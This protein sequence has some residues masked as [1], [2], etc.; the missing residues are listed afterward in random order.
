M[1]PKRRQHDKAEAQ[2]TLI[3]EITDETAETAGLTGRQ[4]LSPRLLAALAKVRREAFVPPS[5]AELA[6]INAPLPIGHGQ[7][8][9]QPFIVAIMTE[10][11]DLEPGDVVLEIGSG[12]GYQAAIL[13]ELARQ[14]YGVEVIPELVENAR[15]ALAAEGYRNV[16]IRCGDGAQ[17]WAEHAPYDA[18][19]VTAAAAQIPPALVAQL[20][21]G[22]RMVVPVGESGRRQ[23]LVLLEKDKADRV[24]Q[25]DIMDVAFVPLVPGAAGSS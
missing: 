14:V 12:S 18:I 24:T 20:R 4:V 15:R 3:A 17:G 19:I 11:L 22:G 10:L 9:S 5:E 21:A 23:I 8:I 13:A 1:A 2:Q 6:Y 16:E 25:R 7:T